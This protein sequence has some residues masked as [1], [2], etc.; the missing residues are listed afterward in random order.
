MKRLIEKIAIC[1]IIATVLLSSIVYAEEGA[2]AESIAI[3]NANNGGSA[4]S[5]VN[6]GV[7]I[8]PDGNGYITTAG[9]SIDLDVTGTS[10]A[11]GNTF[12]EGTTPVDSDGEQANAGVSIDG[13]A[14][15]YDSDSS[16]WLSGT[17]DASASTEDLT[18]NTFANIDA[19]ANNNAKADGIAN[20]WAK[21]FGTVTEPVRARGQMSK[22]I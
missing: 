20:T 3:A 14:L 4:T 10:E 13:Y 16:A 22:Y 8:Y 19:Y 7:S 15:A 6:T 11:Y 5:I 2:R 12:G 21:K 1:C 17:A 9:T 18:A